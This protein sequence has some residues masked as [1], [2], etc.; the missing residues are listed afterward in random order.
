VER[1]TGRIFISALP[2][3]ASVNLALAALALPTILL[4][5]RMMQFVAL[6]AGAA[7]VASLLVVFARGPK[8]A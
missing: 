6:A 8:R 1:R 7:L 5:S 4:A 2:I 3:D